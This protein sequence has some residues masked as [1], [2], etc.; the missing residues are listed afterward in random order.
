MK[1]KD[2]IKNLSLASIPLMFKGIPVYSMDTFSDPVLEVFSSLNASSDNILVIIQLNGGNDGLNTVLALDKY[3]IL[4]NARP[5]ILIPENKA[6][7][8]TDN[9]TT[10]LHPSMVGMQS[11]YNDGKMAIIQ[12]VSYPNPNFSHFHAQDIWF[13]GAGAIGVTGTGWLGRGLDKKYPSYPEG[14]PNTSHPDPAAIQ[15][16]GVT[17]LSLQGPTVNMGY[18]VPNPS[19]LKNIL[20]ESP[21]DVPNN[22]YGNELAFLRLMKS[23][24]NE[25]ADKISASY[26]A[27]NTLSS[28]YPASGNSLATQLQIV[29]RLIGG[30]LSTPVYIVNHENSFDTHIKQVEEGNSLAGD[31]AV[32]LEK[33]SVAISAF[34]NDL[35]LMNKADKVIGMTYS[36]FGRRVVSNQSDGT[37]HGTAAPM[38]VF[39]TKI[40]PGMYGVSPDIPNT[41][42][43]NTQVNTQH[44]YRQVYT[45]IMQNWLGI[46]KTD[47]DQVLYGEYQKINFI[48]SGTSPEPLPIDKI[49]LSLK[50]NREQEELAFVVYSNH[51]YDKFQVEISVNGK[52][53]ELFKEV[54]QIT[55]ENL[56]DYFC[57]IYKRNESRVYYRIK[58]ISKQQEI[59]F[60]NVV[61]V[62]NEDKQFLR[63]YPNPIIDYKFYIEFLEKPNKNVLVE[64]FD[65]RGAKLYYNQYQSNNRI[66]VELPDMFDSNKVYLVRIAFDTEVVTEK[67]FFQ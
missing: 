13:S 41:P 62:K 22:D 16:G 64:V 42:N 58:G 4:S 20:N 17:P 23:Q 26:N 21:G 49:Q 32:F 43:V 5:N 34:M 8:L 51:Y 45:T 33:L 15:I 11:L 28:Q 63:I 7:S 2:F 39:G 35:T 27:Q 55:N 37:D 50:R 40:N 6:L 31:H 57:K 66:S 18:N 44:D 53:F 46:S 3:S 10:G 56:K 61:V 25:Y 65:T 47:S 36:E 29:A 54:L 52:D 30:G 38:F 14:Y 12:G 60:S 67:V 59:S 9:P 19:E 48:N 1:R 24:S